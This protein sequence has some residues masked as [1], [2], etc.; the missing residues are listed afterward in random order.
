MNTALFAHHRFKITLVTL[1]LGTLLSTTFV[2]AH[3]FGG[4]FTHTAGSWL[5]LPYTQWGAYR[6]PVLNATYSWYAR[7]N[8]L[9]PY[10]TANY[11]ISKEDYYSVYVND[12][13]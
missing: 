7:P 2:S 3:F 13:W 8:R 12:T 10:E 6:T 11:Y 5:Y 1:I 4:R 9:I